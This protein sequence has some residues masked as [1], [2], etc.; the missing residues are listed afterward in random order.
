MG[1]ENVVALI[2]ENIVKTTDPDN[3]DK[4]LNSEN[5]SV[6]EL[7]LKSENGWMIVIMTVLMAPVI[8]EFVY[9]YVIFRYTKRVH[10]ALSYALSTILFTLPHMISTN[11][12]SVGVGIWLLQ[13]IPYAASGLLFAVVYHKSNYNI[14]SSI[15]AHILNNLVAVI[16]IYASK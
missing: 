12:S 2:I 6:I 13:C 4:Y 11:I 8:E 10:V 7:M 16:I 9:R 15:A 5:Q 3:I 14:Y 1:I